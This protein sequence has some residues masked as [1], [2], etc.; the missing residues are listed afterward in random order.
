MQDKLYDLTMDFGR[1]GKVKIVK[2]RDKEARDKG[3]T[4]QQIAPEHGGVNGCVNLAVW[5]GIFAKVRKRRAT[6]AA[7]TLTSPL[8]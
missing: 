2:R 1:Q 8:G 6:A 3:T 7:R 4:Y 5:K